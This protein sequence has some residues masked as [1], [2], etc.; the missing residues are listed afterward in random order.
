MP[1]KKFDPHDP[2]DIVVTPVPLEEGRDGLG[3]MA[4]TIIQ[5]YLTIGWSDKAIYQMFKKP[6]YAGPYSIYR[7]RGE[8]YVQRL[9]REEEDKYR[10]RVRN[11]VRKEI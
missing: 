1:T 10:F 2:F 9:I 5:E 11:L 3:D 4:K 7:Q 6:K 8:Q